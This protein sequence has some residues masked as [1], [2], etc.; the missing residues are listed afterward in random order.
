MSKMNWEKI[1]KFY[2]VFVV[3]MILLAVLV[4]MSF[5][6][7][8]NAYLIAFEIDQKGEDELIIKKDNL[9]EAYSW[10]LE[11]KTLPLEVRE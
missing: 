10:A 7:V 4:I 5:R 6:G 2:I 3:V 9:N 8:F 1:D 11:K